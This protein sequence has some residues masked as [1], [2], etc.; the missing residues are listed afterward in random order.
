[1]T[2]QP[3]TPSPPADDGIGKSLIGALEEGAEKERPLG[4][5]YAIRLKT[6]GELEVVF[7]VD[8]LEAVKSRRPVRYWDRVWLEFED[9]KLVDPADIASFSEVTKEQAAEIAA[10][11]EA[12]EDPDDPDE[13]EDEEL[14]PVAELRAALE[15]VRVQKAKE[16][17]T[18][19][20]QPAPAVLS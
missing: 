20:A 9:G 14:P 17:A 16:S 18:A 4:H 5:A 8:P 3:Q 7:D 15:Y 10:G 19:A 12:P 2:T 11:E 13:G 6:S 1:M